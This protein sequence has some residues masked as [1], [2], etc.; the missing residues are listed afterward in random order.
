[1]RRRRGFN[2]LPAIEKEH[3]LPEA[4]RLRAVMRRHHDGCAV[5][6]GLADHLLD[7]F[8]RGEIQ[9][10]C[11]LV[12]EQNVRLGRKRTDQRQ[13]LLL[14]ARQGSGRSVHPV[15]DTGTRHPVRQLCILQTGADKMKMLGSG[16]AH[17]DRFLEHHFLSVSRRGVDCAVVK[18]QQPVKATEK[19]GFAGPVISKKEGDGSPADVERYRVQK[20][21]A[22]AGQADIAR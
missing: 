13:F 7:K 12:E 8:R 21:D 11:R 1:M 14:A 6:V 17:D 2:Q 3:V 5:G 9:V 18:V 16:A 20:A 10:R 19:K 15:L 22:V 4:F